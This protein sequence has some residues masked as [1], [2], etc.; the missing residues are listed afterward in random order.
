MEVI[1]NI[2]LY[3]YLILALSLFC[4]GLIGLVLSNNIIKTLICYELILSAIGINFIAFNIYIDKQ[5][6][7]GHIFQ[8]LIL[9]ISIIQIIIALILLV[10]AN[11]N[12]PHSN[13]EEITSLKE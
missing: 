13:E 4:I 6:S 7:N 5:T 3:H 12:K 2:G 9:I 8:L 11:K 1:T 10:L